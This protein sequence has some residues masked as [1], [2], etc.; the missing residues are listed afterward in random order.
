MNTETMTLRRLTAG[1][2]FPPA[3]LQPAGVNHLYA[4]ITERYP[5]QSLQHLVDGA[6]MFNQEND[7]FIQQTRIQ[8]NETVM[9]FQATKEKCMDLFE[10]TTRQL[11]ITQFLTFGLKLTAFVPMNE[12]PRAAQFIENNMLAG[13]TDKLGALGEGRQGV[14]IRIV[15]HKDGIHEI[16]IEPFFNDLSQLYVEL[17][18]QYPN[19]FGDLMV[20]DG[21]FDAAY[22]YLF[23]EVQQ[24]ISSFE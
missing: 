4:T 9:H 14:G 11:G 16:K 2:I 19:P 15:V 3:G 5:Y 17:D 10:V 6:R 23:G 20:V 22:N 13:L 21:R 1:L 18:V 12:A 7:C 24:F 8:I